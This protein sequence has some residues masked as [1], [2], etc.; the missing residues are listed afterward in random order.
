MSAYRSTET[1]RR[2]RA[3]IA[4]LLAAGW[5]PCDRCEMLVA[6]GEWLCYV[7]ARELAGVR[8]HGTQVA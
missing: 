4:A 6:L 2:L 1:D 8:M 7:C 3:E 5:H